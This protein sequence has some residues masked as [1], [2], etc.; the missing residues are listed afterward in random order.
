MA[1]VFGNLFGYTLNTFDT[2]SSFG[3]TVPAL[4]YWVVFPT[5]T[6]GNLLA[7]YAAAAGDPVGSLTRIYVFRFK[8][9]P[10]I[11]AL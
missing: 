10:S 6:G 8:Q 11:N 4:E 5:D 9:P 7:P 3:G 1:T 2:F